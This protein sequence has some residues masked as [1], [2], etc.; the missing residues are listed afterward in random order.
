MGGRLRNSDGRFARGLNGQHDAGTDEAVNNPDCPVRSWPQK[1]EVKRWV[2][3][4]PWLEVDF[5]VMDPWRY[6][7]MSDIEL[8]PV[9]IWWTRSDCAPPTKSNPSL[10]VTRHVNA[11]DDYTQLNVNLRTLV[12]Y[13]YQQGLT[14]AEKDVDQLFSV[15]NF[16]QDFQ[17]FVNSP[18]SICSAERRELHG[19]G[20]EVREPY[21]D[22]AR[23]AT[24]DVLEGGGLRGAR[25]ILCCQLEVHDLNAPVSL[26]HSPALPASR[27]PHPSAQSSLAV[28][29]RPMTAKSSVEPSYDLNMPDGNWTRTVTVP[30]TWARDKSARLVITPAWA[31]SNPS[32]QCR[33]HFDPQKSSD[34]ARARKCLGIWVCEAQGCQGS[35]RPLVRRPAAKS[36]VLKAGVSEDGDLEERPDGDEAPATA[37]PTESR[38]NV[39]ARDICL[40]CAGPLVQK[41]CDDEVELRAVLRR[42]GMPSDGHYTYFSGG[43]TLITTTI[44]DIR[45]ARWIPVVQTVT[46]S[47]KTE[48]YRRHFAYI[49]KVF[50]D[51]GLDMLETL[52]RL[53]SVVNYSAAQAAGYDAAFADWF[54]DLDFDDTDTFASHLES[55]FTDVSLADNVAAA[56][57]EKPA[58]S[59]IDESTAS[60]RHF[61]A[62]VFRTAKSKRIP[63]ADAAAFT[64]LALG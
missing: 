53:L 6:V 51:G 41:Q 7:G 55:I 58:Y 34:D 27:I 37:A 62:S 10:L 56:I 16:V 1:P 42:G 32:Y 25:P 15:E 46:T 52:V 44:F 12:D 43:F 22:D 64:S 39:P 49:I 24:W 30:V 9:E 8:V 21:E 61:D 31:L 29:S 14:L 26:P 57:S 33:R 17:A 38:R 13:L 4:N 48:A 3:P 40:E 59:S 11:G 35:G 60:L 2:K 19:D 50:V 45:L 47:E 18:D 36:K 23:W 5:G 54:S 63:T 28:P 20:V